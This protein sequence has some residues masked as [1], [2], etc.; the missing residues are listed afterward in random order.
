MKF[1]IVLVLSLAIPTFFVARRDPAA[2]KKLN[3]VSTGTVKLDGG[4][5]CVSFPTVALD[6]GGDG[7]EIIGTLKNEFAR[8]IDDLKIVV[9][10]KGT[11]GTGPSS[12][13]PGNN[14]ATI[15]DSSG[16]QNEG[17]TDIQAP[18][19]THIGF[20][21]SFTLE[22]NAGHLS[23][24][25]PNNTVD[26]GVQI[27]SRGNAVDM[28]ICFVPSFGKKPKG[29]NAHAD[30]MEAFAFKGDARSA[31]HSMLAM[32]NDRIVVEIK[33]SDTTRAITKLEGSVGF[34]AIGNSISQVYLQDPAEEYDPPAGV[35]YLITNGTSFT[36]SD[37]AS[38]PPGQSYELIIVFAAVPDTDTTLKSLDLRLDATLAN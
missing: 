27:T 23:P 15:T 6:E 22:N 33:N 9:R 37:F 38:L 21:S 24:I 18:D 7:P 30:V 10:R 3:A 28:E 29:S 35:Q 16:S 25:T 5:E 11:S 13:S 8:N 17:S 20:S 36:V 19:G 31:M 14:D 4:T 12:S 32:G 26:F 2:S 34:P 1:L